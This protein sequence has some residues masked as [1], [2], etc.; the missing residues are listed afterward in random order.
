MCRAMAGSYLK[1]SVF[2]TLKYLLRTPIS[3]HK[4]SLSMSPWYPQGL[5][6]RIYVAPGGSKYSIC[7]VSSQ[8]QNYDSQ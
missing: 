4:N 3:N 6:F 5:L 1:S 7:K 2:T 8:K